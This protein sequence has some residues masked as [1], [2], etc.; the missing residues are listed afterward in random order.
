MVTVRRS[1]LSAVLLPSSV[2]IFSGDSV[3]ADSGVINSGGGADC[4]GLWKSGPNDF[5]IRDNAGG[6]D[7]D[8]CYIDYGKS[9]KQAG[10][11]N[12]RRISL[13]EDCFVDQW[14]AFTNPDLSGIG[15]QIYFQVCEEREN[16]PDLCSNVSGW[17]K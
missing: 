13:C 1:V 12:A 9:A 7:D 5:W 14:R 6:N 15:E 10:G 3:D 8:Y 17:A 16:D 4:S 2:A 11:S